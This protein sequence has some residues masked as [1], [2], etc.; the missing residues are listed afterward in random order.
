MMSYITPIQFVHGERK[1]KQSQ[2]RLEQLKWFNG[3]IKQNLGQ[4]EEK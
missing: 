2:H 4:A 1:G 3:Q